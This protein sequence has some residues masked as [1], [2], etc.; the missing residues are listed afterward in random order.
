ME[1]YGGGMA[2]KTNNYPLSGRLT[3]AKRRRGFQGEIREL[4]EKPEASNRRKKNTDFFG[5]IGSLA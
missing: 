3:S 2:G 1:L 5:S 4:R